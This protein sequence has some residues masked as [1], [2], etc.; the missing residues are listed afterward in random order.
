MP[1]VSDVD[2][3]ELADGT[4]TGPRRRIV[5]A[6]LAKH[7]ELQERLEVFRVT[8]QALAKLFDPV[9]RA[10][11]PSGLLEAIQHTAP[12]HASRVVPFTRSK[13]RVEVQPPAR[14]W[15]LS[16]GMVLA[17]A[18]VAAV[19]I[20]AAIWSLQSDSGSGFVA[21]PLA[22]ALE[23]TPS[24]RTAGLELPGYGPGVFKADLSF[25]HVD[26]RYCRQYE[27]SFESGSGFAGYACGAGNGR[28]RIEKEAEVTLTKA[29]VPSTIRP[30]GQNPGVKAIDDAVGSVIRGDALEPDRE[31]ALIRRGW[32]VE[33]KQ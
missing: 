18:L 8:G 2:L 32:Q 22:L 27:L 12:A 26:G 1:E 28:W 21:T 20:G 17:A 4:L 14:S 19:G 33:G 29:D 5:E 7:P 15:A 13:G 6:E 31:L 16:S 9:V 25:Q 3:M 10:P 30:A 11:L 23:K 24:A